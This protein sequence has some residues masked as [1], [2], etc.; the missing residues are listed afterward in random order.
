MLGKQMQAVRVGDRVRTSSTTTERPGR[1]GEVVE[2]MTAPDHER[3]RVRWDDGTETIMYA[4]ADLVV[5][6]PRTDE[7]AATT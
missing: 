1:R 7:G 5:E 4:G 6:T 2:V 3:C